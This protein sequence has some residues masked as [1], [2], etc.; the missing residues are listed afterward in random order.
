MWSVRRLWMVQRVL[1]G[2]VGQ[3]VVYRKQTQGTP[4]GHD[5]VPHV[6]A[7][8]SQYNALSSLHP[9][10]NQRSEIQQNYG[11]ISLS[12]DQIS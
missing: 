2:E 5:L 11:E 9:L 1:V 7:I 8:F 6:T 3:D 12:C 10:L 4:L